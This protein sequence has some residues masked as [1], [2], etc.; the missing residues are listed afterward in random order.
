VFSVN[1]VFVRLFRRVIENIP[2]E[3]LFFY[4]KPAALLK[5]IFL[6][7]GAGYE[8]ETVFRGHSWRGFDDGR[9]PGRM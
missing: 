6:Q 5:I 8:K 1:W 2:A 4:A 7:R 3:G 9:V